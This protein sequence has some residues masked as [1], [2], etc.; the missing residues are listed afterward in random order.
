MGLFNLIEEFN[1]KIETAQNK[2][3]TT[4]LEVLIMEKAA[5][6]QKLKK[7][8]QK[9][10]RIAKQI[11]K[12]YYAD[13]P[14]TPYISNERKADWLEKAQIFPKQSIIPKSIMNRFSD[15]L[16][17]GHI[18]MLYW[19]KK[20]TNKIVPSYFE[21]KYGIDF[22]KEKSFLYSG[23]YLDIDNKPTE[24]GEAAIKKHYS[25]IEKH[26]PP[27][28]DH[29]IEGISKQILLQRDSMLKNGFK[30]YTFIANSSC[31]DICAKLNDK[32][33]KVKDLKIGVNAPPMH[34]KCSCSIAAYED[35]KEY[36]E[37]L[38]NL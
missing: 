23:G 37:W 18:Y 13:Y 33:F 25:I 30:E 6:K 21:F 34:E 11:I 2:I 15:G 38:N 4:P 5:A 1:K 29:S 10:S 28:P 3:A 12:L 35:S 32:H 16:L 7:E 22:E 14:E 31:C 20:H 27:K 19:L 36:E 24:K 8:T 17:P 26:T 9:Q